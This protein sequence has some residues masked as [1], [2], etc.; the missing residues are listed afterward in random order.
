MALAPEVHDQVAHRHD[1]L[2]I[3]AVGR[4][5]EDQQFRVLEQ[6]RRHPDPLPHPHRVGLVL[7]VRAGHHL[8]DSE[9]LL[10]VGSFQPPVLR[11][12]LEVVVAGEVAV[13]RRTLNEG[14]DL[15]QSLGGAGRV[16]GHG[17]CSRVGPDE[18]GQYAQRRRLA[19]A[20]GPQ[21]AVDLAPVD[22]HAEVIDG[23]DV[24]EAF[25]QA[26]GL[27][28]ERL[29]GRGWVPRWDWE[30]GGGHGDTSLTAGSAVG[31][32]QALREDSAMGRFAP[33]CRELRLFPLEPSPRLGDPNPLSGPHAKQV[34][35]RTRRHR[36]DLVGRGIELKSSIPTGSVGRL[37]GPLAGAQADRRSGGVSHP[38]VGETRRAPDLARWERR[39]P[40]GSSQS[41]RLAGWRT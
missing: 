26:A 22:P 5:V 1:A 24:A 15:G 39:R 9:R 34:K 7:V 17:G 14:P 29:L 40:L 16:A 25:G 10:D 37:R 13:E 20:V 36:Q 30:I 8:H 28:D 33:S 27:D 4:L 23:D 32:P 35:P 11:D 3:E 21:E 38:R 2:R 31:C 41:P 12:H 6:G 18:P 19:G